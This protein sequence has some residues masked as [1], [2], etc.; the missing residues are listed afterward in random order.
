[1]EGPAPILAAPCAALA[2]SSRR[3]GSRK[4]RATAASDTIRKGADR[5]EIGCERY[6]S[7]GAAHLGA[8]VD[9]GRLLLAGAL[10]KARRQRHLLL[11]I[12]AGGDS[13]AGLAGR[14]CV[15]R[16]RHRPCVTLLLQSVARLR[17]RRRVAGPQVVMPALAGP[18]EAD[19]RR[20]SSSASCP[21]CWWWPSSP[22]PVTMSA[23][24]ATA[25]A[26][27]APT[28]TYTPRAIVRRPRP[29]V[30][31]TRECPANGSRDR[32]RTGDR[33]GDRG[34][35]VERHGA[36]RR[37]RAA[38]AGDLPLLVGFHQLQGQTHGARSDVTP[39]APAG[40]GSTRA[41]PP[42]PRAARP[43][44]SETW[45]AACRSDNA[46]Q[47]STPRAGARSGRA[48]MPAASG[49]W[50]KL[51]CRRVVKGGGMEGPRPF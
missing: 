39:P 3:P 38:G 13:L 34:A 50:S 42:P 35:A 10:A 18:P 21:C 47:Q 36:L 5:R 45:P 25:G 43:A 2:R 1:M 27:P 9:A 19:P 4:T 26:T 15:A 31:P 33:G 32:R 29:Q 44:G 22:W 12:V 46:R 8:V 11:P 7:C 37:A 14:L 51:R 20:M 48:G 6:G 17:R 16:A 23:L 30:S 28:H 49:P 24:S 41:R 40:P